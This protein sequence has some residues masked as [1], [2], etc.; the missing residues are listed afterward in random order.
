[1]TLSKVDLFVQLKH[2]LIV[3]C[4][5][6]TG[7][8]LNTP[9]HLAAIAATAVIGGASGIRASKPANIQAIRQVVD[10][11]IIGIYKKDYPGF[12]VRIT[13]TLAEVEA[14]VAA[15]SD[16]IALD[17]T[18]RPRPDGQTFAEL[19]QIIRERFDVPIMADISTYEEGLF[20]AQL[21]VDLVATTLSGYA[22]HSKK[23]VG[24]D[25]EL[26]Q[27]LAQ[28]IDV[29]VVTE[30]RVGNAEEVRAALD[31][32][33]FAV[34]VGS[35]ITR[36][37]LITEYFVSGTRPKQ[38]PETILTL[39]IGGTKIAGAVVNGVGQFLIKD[40]VST[41]R[42]EGGSAVLDKAIRLLKTIREQYD[43]PPPEA[44]GISTGGQVDANGQIIGGTRMLP[45]WIG[46][47]LKEAV[48]DRFQLPTSVLN[49]GHA[50]ALAEAHWGA[51]RDRSSMLCVVIGTG[52][53]GGLVID[54]RLQHGA[55]GLAGSVGQMKVSL[56]GQSHVPL[57]DIVSGP[58]LLRAY[59]ERV[60]PAETGS[61]A[62]EVA[63]RSQ[64]G[65]E[66]AR[67]T[68]DDMGWWLGLGLSHALHAY[69]ADCVVVGGS[70]ALIG[71]LLLESARRSLKRHGHMTVAD[72]PIL[73]A[74]FGPN[75]QLVGAAAYARQME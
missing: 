21:G 10:V 7:F 63:Q 54:G 66:I 59:N 70:V 42:Q 67:E 5:A 40:E 62:Q 35:M 27:Q 71:D 52:L 15:G 47:P 49:D 48:A 39:D 56:D 32:G 58:G 20:V 74:A 30:G 75:A 61:S 29:P 22:K 44:I 19:Y 31:A 57:E 13:P 18:N 55:H 16:I 2:S 28:A 11:P 33:A 17:A 50:A 1:M 24:P 43:G 68:I 53:G 60:G 3:S 69:D 72:T 26:V 23:I 9:D 25:L 12:D 8:P 6:E 36:P 64:A 46:I 14:I 4:Q 34:V 38:K 73:P 37:H 41:S 51:G 65:D 45:D